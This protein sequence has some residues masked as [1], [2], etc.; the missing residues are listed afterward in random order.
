MQQQRL[1][2]RHGERGQ[3]LAETALFLPLFLLVLF[4]V[5]WAVQSS[6]VTERAQM[7]VRFSGLVSDEVNPYNQYSLTALYNGLP[8]VASSETYSCTS[9][10]DEA[11]SNSGSFP[12]PT[13]APFFQPTASPSGSCT[14]GPVELSGG[15]MTAPMLFVGTQ[16]S[17]TAQVSVPT[18]LQK[19]LGT[20]QSVSATQNFFDGP[21][22]QTF[23]ACYSTLGSAVMESLTYY[24][25][26]ASTAPTPLPQSP[27]ETPLALSTPC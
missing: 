11:F 19:L 7:A 18:Y 16:S 25:L 12:G 17:V 4:G 20:T 23:L 27:N 15:T 26:N 10:D 13:T 5:I 6:V 1:R 24:T 22:V 2:A 3:A 8:G 9:P 14:Q 21:D